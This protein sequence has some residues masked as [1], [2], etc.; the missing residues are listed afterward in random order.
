M[1]PRTYLQARLLEHLVV[2]KGLVEIETAADKNTDRVAA[3]LIHLLRCYQATNAPTVDPLAPLSLS[4]RKRKTHQP[5]PKKNVD[6]AGP[7]A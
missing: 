2:L 4:S 6:P 5:P 3:S 1:K 7:G